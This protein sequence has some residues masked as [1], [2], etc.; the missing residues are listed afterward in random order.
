MVTSTFP[1]WNPIKLIWNYAHFRQTGNQL[2]WKSII[3]ITK[4][5]N[6]QETIN[7]SI[8]LVFIWAIQYMKIDQLYF[9]KLCLRIYNSTQLSCW[10]RNQISFNTGKSRKENKI[11]EIKQYFIFN[12]HLNPPGGLIICPSMAEWLADC[13]VSWGTRFRIPERQ[14]YS[15]SLSLLCARRTRIRIQNPRDWRKPSSRDTHR[16]NLESINSVELE[17]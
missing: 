17:V 11:D 15:R 9:K 2:N 3:C 14:M 12:F 1:F 6:K 5:F 4:K 8:T 16:Y 10:L 13:H 7:N